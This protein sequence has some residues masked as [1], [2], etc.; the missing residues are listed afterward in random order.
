MIANHLAPV[1]KT[2]GIVPVES[3]GKMPAQ[4]KSK[5]D[6]PTSGNPFFD[7]QRG[8]GIVVYQFIFIR[9]G[10]ICAKVIPKIKNGI[11]PVIGRR[12]APPGYAFLLGGGKRNGSPGG[13]LRINSIAVHINATHMWALA[14]LILIGFGASVSEVALPVFALFAAVNADE[15]AHGATYGH[16]NRHISGILHLIF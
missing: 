2:P 6:A 15:V 1:T 10:P 9:Q 4:V 3:I 16:L 13:I 11:F 7:S 12:G 14:I 5:T 8:H